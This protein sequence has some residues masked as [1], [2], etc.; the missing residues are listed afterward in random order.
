MN[1]LY[2][3]VKRGKIELVSNLSELKKIANIEYKFD[4]IGFTEALYSCDDYSWD[5][6]TNK[7]VIYS[8][9]ASN[10]F[11]DAINA[12]FDINKSKLSNKKL[13]FLNEL[14]EKY[15]CPSIESGFY[16][17]KSKWNFLVRNILKHKNTLLTGP[18]GT[19]KTDIVIRICKELNVP[20]R[21]YDMGAMMDPLTD[22]LGQHKLKDGN[23][24]FEYSRF[25]EDIQKPGVILLDEISRAPFGSNNILFP[26]LD[27]R[28]TLPVDIAGVND[29]REIKVH[30]ECV[31]IATANIGSE[32]SGTSELDAALLNRFITLQV[33]YLPSEIEANVIKVNYNIDNDIVYDIVNFAN[34][35]RNKYINGVISKPIS[36]RE[37]LACA[38]LISDG[39]TFEDSIKF[40]MCEKFQKYGD[41][42]EYNTV[43][44]ALMG[45]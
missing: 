17:E 9:K 29:N 4:N 32:Y 14:T 26:C 35:I 23:S 6:K 37:T 42:P 8:V 2:F 16:F 22:L 13:S 5:P 19:G 44:G 28:R 33:D 1:T 34:D 40:S 43:I 10:D 30:P 31:F 12:S 18:T 7:L 3:S 45:Y 41:N 38:E 25:V 24:V 36:T 20:C 15:P 11:D 39:F 27:M 21:I